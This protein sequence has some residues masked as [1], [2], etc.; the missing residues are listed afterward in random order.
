MQFYQIFPADDDDDDDDSS[1]EQVEYALHPEVEEI[2]QEIMDR[3]AARIEAFDLQYLVRRPYHDLNELSLLPGLEDASEEEVAGFLIMMFPNGM[4][5]RKA[6]NQER[7]D[8]IT[9]ELQK[10]SFHE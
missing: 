8:E 3:D 5:L 1:T 2:A 6:L 10:F 4:A 9:G 7:F